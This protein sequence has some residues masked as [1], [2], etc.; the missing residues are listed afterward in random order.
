MQALP[1][2]L[3]G[4]PKNSESR[5]A[6]R[7]SK[8]LLIW[9]EVMA[10]NL[11][12]WWQAWSRRGGALR[13]V[14]VMI[15]ATGT[16]VAAAAPSSVPAFDAGRDLKPV[17]A[18]F[19]YPCHG[20]EKK[21][22]ELDLEQFATDP[23][24]ARNRDLWEKVRNSLEGREM[25]PE[26]KAQPTELVRLA[27]VEAIDGQLELAEAALPANPGRVTIRRLN[28]NEYRNT[29]RDLLGVDYDAH[30]AFP[31]DESGY[32][33]DNIG[34]VL[35]LPPM[36]MEKYLAAA[37]DIAQR[38]IQTTDP[39]RKRVKRVPA[40]KWATQ[41][42]AVS[43]VEE[44][45]WGFYREGEITT[46]WEFPAAGEYL[47]RLKAYGDQAGPELPKLGVRFDGSQIHVQSV[48]AQGDRPETF[49]VRLQASAGKHKLGV[50]YLNNFNAD[51]DRNVYL[52]GAE[53]VGPLGGAP[54][55]YPEPHR[56]LL[57]RR[58]EAGKESEFA[59]EVLGRFAGR[60]FRRPARDEEV[61]RLVR[62]VEGARKEGLGFEAAMQV[63]LQA[64]LVSPH[65]LFRWELDP[66]PLGPGEARELGAYEVASRLSY[67]L[68]SS[69]P[70]D[71]L[72]GLAA[73]NALLEPATLEA[74]V[75]RMLR[76]PKASAL[77]RNFGGQWLQIRNLDQV[78]PDPTVFPGWDG[79]L[80]DAMRQETELYLQ[81]VVQEDRR[82]QELV[83]SDFTFLNEKL[84]RH[85]RIEGVSGPEFRRVTLP[86]D[87]GR[88]GVVTM[89]SVLTITSVPTRTAPV[90]R[91]KWILEQV[92]G[93]PPPPPPP[94][95]PP[96]ETGAEAVQAATLRQRLE[97]HRSK[98]DCMGCHQKMDALGFALEH[99]DAVGAWRDKDGPHPIDSAAE[100]PGG[101]KVGGSTGL[102][103]VLSQ[104]DAFP[105]ALATKLLTY[106]LGR[107]LEHYD[108]RAVKGIVE[109]L[110][111]N[112]F[113][114]SALVLGIVRSEPFLK[115]QPEAPTHEQ[116]ASLH[117]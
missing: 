27:V 5:F 28:R 26:G 115:R 81:A 7:T 25:P 82:V 32:G 36:L 65:F 88:G 45:V 34:D 19:C 97:L 56:R 98:P 59:R 108:R 102:K 8:A 99:F 84:A 72:L 100:L 39:A 58:P 52:V 4:D 24:F 54:D 105:K 85:Y 50:A 107:G 48:K 40:A 57:P 60:A 37:E 17:L 77:V 51:G 35:S 31:N 16:V 90:L 86:K 10:K 13:A 75:R 114:F 116:H 38:V 71:E 92:L 89:G 30:A 14:V 104:S 1:P 44:E 53:I 63:A 11:G 29:I 73:R 91:G 96:V 117:P 18:E 74:Q 2:R 66:R 64:V 41:A 69:L 55:E 70:D 93:T 95:V 76:D 103:E 3:S 43:T 106:A 6:V 113:R 110:E 109:Q 46:E 23:A 21:K 49:E 101:R 47:W 79:A 111:K 61:T 87:S 42:D 67:F 12:P 94:N 33:F 112:D 9:S 22:G 80:R 62:L 78:E 15:G 83:D 68:W 20:K